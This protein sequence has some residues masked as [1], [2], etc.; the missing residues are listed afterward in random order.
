MIAASPGKARPSAVKPYSAARTGAVIRLKEII[1]SQIG[2][3]L[4]KTFL[5]LPLML[6]CFVLSA[7][8]Q[9][10]PSTQSNIAAIKSKTRVYVPGNKYD[11]TSRLIKSSLSKDKKLEIVENAE[12]AHFVLDYQFERGNIGRLTAF[13]YNAKKQKIVYWSETKA[14]E[15]GKH[16]TIAS[17]ENIKF[18]VQSFLK[19]KNGK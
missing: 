12:K 13:S 4:M 2:D 17:A 16:A 11:Q 6:F 9:S 1:F 15:E 5:A 18:L 3:H 14:Q 10:D 8:G 7:S 19:A